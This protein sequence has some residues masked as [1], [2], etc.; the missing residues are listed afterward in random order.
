MT[1]E[2]VKEKLY[3]YIE[4]ADQNKV[5]AIYTLVKEDPASEGMIERGEIYDEATLN[6]LEE[7]RKNILSG[8]VETY[9]LEESKER[10]K[11]FRKSH[12]V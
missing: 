9:S 5:M 1:Y 2:S 7:R 4:H 12:G 3:W 10:I 11:Q 6:I 8:N